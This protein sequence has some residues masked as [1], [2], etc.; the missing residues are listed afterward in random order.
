MAIRNKIERDVSLKVNFIICGTQKG[1]TSALDSYLRGHPEICMANGKELHF[2]DTESNFLNV[3]PDYSI[4]HSAFSPKPSHKVLGEATPIYMYWYDAPRRIWQYNSNMKLIVVLRN[5]I[6]RAY[7]HWNMQRSRKIENSSF[8]DAMHIER[9]RC[10]EELPYQHRLYSYIDRGF[11]LEQ[12]RRLWCYF[13]EEQILILRNEHL[14]NQPIDVLQ[15]VCRFLQVTPFQKIENKDVH[16]HPYALPMSD[17]ER[18]YLRSIYEYE[19]RG[20]ERVL[21]WDCSDW[22]SD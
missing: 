8:W 10:R 3:K 1:G 12:L 16:S 19:V 11:Y 4:Y 18:D 15:D 14:K 5:P 20:L 7:S 17:K 22:L 13:P 6:D 2:F 9:A 21:G